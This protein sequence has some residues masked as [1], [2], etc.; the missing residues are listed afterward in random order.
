MNK[1]S[2]PPLVPGDKKLSI[3]KSDNDDLTIDNFLSPGTNGG[4]EFL[5]INGIADYPNNTLEIYNRWGVLVYETSG[6]DNVNHV[7]SGVSEGRVTLQQSQNLPEG[8]YYY[9]LKYTKQ[10][11]E[12]RD[13]A[14]YLYITRK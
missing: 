5:F 3:V 8:T 1:N 10:N 2:L 6:Y 7:F 11:G 12:S 9:I 4:N 13:K 14:G